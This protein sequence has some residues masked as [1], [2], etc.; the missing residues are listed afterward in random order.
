MGLQL[1]V[2]DAVPL[3]GRAWGARVSPAD[4]R[5]LGGGKGRGSRSVVGVEIAEFNAA[6]RSLTVDPDQLVVLNVGT[7]DETV[8]IEIGQAQRGDHG[9]FTGPQ[10]GDAAFLLECRRQLPSELA[11]L[12]ARLIAEI[13]HRFSGEMLEGQNR[14]W[15]NGPVNFIAIT[16]QHRDQSLAVHVKGNA[17]QIAAH[18]LDVRPDRPGYCRFKLTADS[19]LPEALKLIFNSAEVSGASIAAQSPT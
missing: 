8:F 7:S 17:D 1:L 9:E 2:K 12:A 14:K 13:R 6:T 19:Q 3:I 16:I 11:R 18:T 4:L 5:K 10:S 15:V